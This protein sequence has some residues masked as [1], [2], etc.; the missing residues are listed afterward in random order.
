MF[1]EFS[2]TTPSKSLHVESGNVPHRTN[3]F[4]FFLSVFLDFAL[5]KSLS[6]NFILFQYKMN[7]QLNCHTHHY[8]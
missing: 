7:P 3:L 8:N 1:S 4:R 2:H 5:K 6:Q